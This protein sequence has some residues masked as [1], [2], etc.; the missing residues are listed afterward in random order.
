MTRSPHHTVIEETTSKNEVGAFTV[1]L[2]ELE[3][4]GHI[5]LYD[6]IVK[7]SHDGTLREIKDIPEVKKIINALHKS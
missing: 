7:R 6:A 1:Y 4:E 2:H 5:M 3:R